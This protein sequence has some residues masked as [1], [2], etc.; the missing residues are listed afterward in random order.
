MSTPQL[1]S[2]VVIRF[3]FLF[4]FSEFI[5]NVILE[6]LSPWQS[7]TVPM[8]TEWDAADDS[9]YTEH[10]SDDDDWPSDASCGP[11]TQADNSHGKDSK[12]SRSIRKKKRYLK[13]KQ[14]SPNEFLY[15]DKYK[16]SFDGVK[17]SCGLCSSSL[18]K[19]NTM[20]THIRRIHMRDKSNYLCQIKKY[21]SQL[22]ST[23]DYFLVFIFRIY[24]ERY[25]GKAI[26]ISIRPRVNRMGCS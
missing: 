2:L 18:F 3:H 12:P 11:E 8:S 17:Y 15:A 23:W 22:F 26:A 19:R 4:L 21:Y 16:I 14:V 1:A 20:T 24:P 6:K 25:I 9:E 7:A 13:C 10:K 5:P